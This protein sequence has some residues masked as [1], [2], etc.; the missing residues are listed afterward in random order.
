MNEPAI[1]QSKRIRITNLF[2]QNVGK[3]YDS[4][5]LHGMFGSSFRTRVSEINR[6]PESPIRILNETHS[7]DEQETSVYW[8]ELRIPG[9]TN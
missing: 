6:D 2:A 3:R 5:N 7:T 9:G 4:A 1:R 8:A